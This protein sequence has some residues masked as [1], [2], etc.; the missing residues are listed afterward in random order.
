M[1]IFSSSNGY[2][3]LSGKTQVER[4]EMTLPVWWVY[5]DRRTLSLIR[6]LSRKNVSYISIDQYDFMPDRCRITLYFMF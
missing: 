6:L 2:S 1:W 5:E 3:T 4:H